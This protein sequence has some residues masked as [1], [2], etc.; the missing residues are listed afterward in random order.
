[1]RFLL[2]L[3][4]LIGIDFTFSWPRLL[5]GIWLGA[6]LVGWLAG[7]LVVVIPRSL[8]LS[9]L[10]RFLAYWLGF[11]LFAWHGREG[12]RWIRDKGQKEKRK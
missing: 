2:L 6:L 5:V 1:M 9:L 7:W 11:C 3:C 8:L 12:K 4:Y 10:L